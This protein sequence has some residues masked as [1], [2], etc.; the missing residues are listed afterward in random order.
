MLNKLL[1]SMTDIQFR[2]TTED[3]Y[4]YYPMGHFSHGYVLPDEITYNR[5]R[6]FAKISHVVFMAWAVIAGTIIS[7]YNFVISSV[8]IAIPIVVYI[9]KIK[10]MTNGMVKTHEGRKYY[11]IIHGG[12]QSYSQTYLYLLFFISVLFAISGVIFIVI[13]PGM[14]LW[15]MVAVVATI[16][17]AIM[18]WKMICVKRKL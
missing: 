13:R 17:G 12:A 4:I 8:F 10:L 3:K 2:K 11:E 16:Y 18:C 9:A 5:I 14:W 7:N 15:S 1:D 6:R